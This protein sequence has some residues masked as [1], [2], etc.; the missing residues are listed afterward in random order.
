MTLKNI[1]IALSLALSACATT[2]NY[3]KALNSWVGAD[4]DSLV[5][6]WGPPASSY[7]LSNGGKVIEYVRQSN[8]Q[9][10][11]YTT[12]VP[13]TTY[14]SGSA[15]I[16]G[17]GGSAYGTYTGTSTTYVQRTT[18]VQNIRM[19]CITRFTVDAN[20]KITNWAW[21]GN[22]CRARE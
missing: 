11:G 10:G 6:R 13:Q 19:T 12:S 17:T 22:A 8:V 3:E 20:G 2:A 18:P 7:A 4:V 21:Q 14:N 16:Y 15:N 5:M 9:V 1:V